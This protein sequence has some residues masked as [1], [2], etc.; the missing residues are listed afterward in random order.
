MSSKKWSRL[1][2]LQLGRYA[3]Y[4]AKME[5][6][7]YGFYVY[8]SEVD[9]HGIDFIA[10][11]PDLK[12]LFFVQV[13]SV[14][15][16][17]YTY[18]KKEKTILDDNYLVCLIYFTDDHDPDMYIFPTSVWE[19]SNVIFVDR[20]YSGSKYKSKPEWGISYSKKNSEMLEKYTA[21]NFFERSN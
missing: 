9:D 8:A 20:E 6:T 10:Q 3:E 13:K 7:S 15:K 19:N 5:F 21:E 18:L 16:H 1:N 4:Y 11:D 17:N 14:R 12:E 2:H